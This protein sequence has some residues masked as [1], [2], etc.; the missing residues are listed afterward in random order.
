MKIAVLFDGAGL[1]RLGLEQAGHDCT[2]Y[3]L[4][5]AMHHL[6]KMV[7]SGNSVLADVR[8]VDLSGYDGVWASPP[9]QPRSIAR[10]GSE[11]AITPYASDLLGW[12]LGLLQ[13]RFKVV[14]IENV[15]SGA[16]NGWGAT[17]N[18]GQFLPV[19]IQNRNRVI[20]GY[21]P[22][23]AVYR[24]YRRT[25]SNV[26]PAILATEY[27]VGKVNPSLKE[28]RRAGRFYGRR[29]TIEECAYHQGFDIPAAWRTSLSG[30]TEKAWERELYHAIGNGVPVYM[31]RA[32]GEAAH[33]NYRIMTCSR[34][35]QS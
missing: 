2:G 28:Q 10:N 23:P 18:A 35:A 4:N 15:L 25:Y 20:G 13:Q 5:P 24:A 27:K 22:I 9:C 26:C 30:Y 11:A 29:M 1:A 16:G 32:F 14:W 17:W 33:G 21:Y 12:S 7:G 34:Q 3:E 8:D 19:P 6:S 31:A